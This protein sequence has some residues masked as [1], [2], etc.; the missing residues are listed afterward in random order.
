MYKFL[1]SEWIVWVLL[2]GGI[3]LYQIVQR[4][5]EQYIFIMLAYFFVCG[6]IV[7]A[8]NKLVQIEYNSRSTEI[9]EK[10]LE[11]SKFENNTL[12]APAYALYLRP[13][14]SDSDGLKS[15]MSK[16]S[17]YFG[18]F[19]F[20]A[21]DRGTGH[22]LTPEA[23]LAESIEDMLRLPLVVVGIPTSDIDSIEGAGRVLLD[24]NWK[25]E[26]QELIRYSR[27]I[28]ILPSNNEG[29]LFEVETIVSNTAFLEKTVFL[30]PPRGENDEL[31]AQALDALDVLNRFEGYGD[32]PYWE[33]WSK[34]WKDISMSGRA[35]FLYKDGPVYNAANAKSYEAL[36]AGVY[37]LAL[38][39]EY[40]PHRE[41]KSG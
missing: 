6:I 31:D 19:G 11:L 4:Y 2:L 38:R 8:R 10:V 24:S 12:K 1:R 40:Y 13:F 39:Y 30:I 9:V 27:L 35:V 36:M 33:T 7:K 5:V 3:I 15:G 17:F 26:V 14:L 18:G 34:E 22:S 21:G 29:T 16:L 37:R 28:I 25:N 32:N 23:K 20:V 41:E